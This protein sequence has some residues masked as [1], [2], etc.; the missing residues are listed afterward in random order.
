[1]ATITSAQSGN[2]SDIATWVG[3]V[4]PGPADIAVAAN[5]HV[6][7]ID[8]DVTVTK[9]TQAGTGKFTL[10]NGRTLTAL[11]EANTGTITS[12]GTVEVVATTNAS[13]IGNLV[14]PV[15]GGGSSAVVITGSGTVSI[16]GS[17]SETSLSNVGGARAVLYINAASQVTILGSVTGAPGLNG[18]GVTIN[19]AA[20]VTINGNITGGASGSGGGTC[21]AVSVQGTNAS[22]SVFGN[23]SGGSGTFSPPSGIVV[24][25]PNATCTVTGNVTGGS[26]SA[27]YGIQVTGAN[28]STVIYGNVTGNLSTSTNHG[29]YVSSSTGS[30]TVVGAVTATGTAAHGIRSDA[31]S[32]GVIVTGNITDHSSGTTAIYSRLLRVNASTNARTV[33]ANSVGFPNGAPVI[34][35][36]YDVAGDHPLPSNVRQGTSYAY[37]QFTGTMAVPPAN[38]VGSGVPVDNTVGTAVVTIADLAPLTGAQIAAAVTSLP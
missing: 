23:V 2:F 32:N 1:M 7:V 20:N 31:T 25:G 10:G 35:A 13:I 27:S 11:V 14:N 34:R 18:V 29:V 8:I 22:V 30:V 19:V 3:G 36:S 16:L 26:G 9:V 21:H 33:Y 6:V 37:G 5:G 38:S 4:V 15:G 28:A 17:I 24:S 12:G